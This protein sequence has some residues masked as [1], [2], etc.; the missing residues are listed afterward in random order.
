[1]NIFKLLEL[2]FVGLNLSK[3]TMPGLVKEMLEY[4]LM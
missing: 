4:E 3:N 1:M 2:Y